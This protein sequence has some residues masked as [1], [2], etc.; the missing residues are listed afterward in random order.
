MVDGSYLCVRQW[1]LFPYGLGLAA[2]QSWCVLVGSHRGVPEETDTRSKHQTHKHKGPFILL[3]VL[4]SGKSYSS[5]DC[6]I[7]QMF[8]R[9]P[10]LPVGVLNDKPFFQNLFYIHLISWLCNWLIKKCNFCICTDFDWFV[11]LNP[12]GINDQDDVKN[13]TMVNLI[14]KMLHFI[15]SLLFKIIRLP[16]TWLLNF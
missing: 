4:L 12:N 1:V 5:L 13:R 3:V 14:S 16:G 9:S 11:L 2:W 6:S 15:H 7:V 10:P 8:V